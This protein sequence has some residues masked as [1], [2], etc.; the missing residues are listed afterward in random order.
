MV[1]TGSPAPASNAVAGY[2]LGADAWMGLT[3]MNAARCG[4]V[5]VS[6]GSSVL[7]FGGLTDC[8]NGTTTG[9]GL[10]V[11]APDGSGG[12][13]TTVSATGEPG[14]RY[15]LAAAW[16]G[17]AMLVY[18][19]SDNVTSALSTGGLFTPSSGTWADASCSL[20]GCARGGALAAFLDGAVVR[21]WEDGQPGLALDVGTKAWSSGAAPTAGKVAQ[22]YADDGRRIYFIKGTNLVSVYDRKTS[23]WLADDISTTAPGLCSDA[24]TAWS[25][26]EVIAWSGDCG[27]GPVSAGG[28]YQPPAPL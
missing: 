28:R 13:W 20:A 11:Y 17:T 14:H 8:A 16:T 18:G 22:R 3:P 15:N 5:A 27:A 23:S 26:S 2:D 9:P 19:G 25:G 10:E 12:T 6:T 7:A 21:V 1:S 4:H 24:A